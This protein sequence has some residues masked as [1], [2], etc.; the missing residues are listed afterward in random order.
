MRGSGLADHR[1]QRAAQAGFQGAVDAHG[2]GVHAQVAAAE[3]GVRHQA[4]LRRQV[5]QRGERGDVVRVQPHFHLA[6]AAAHASIA[7]PTSCA[8]SAGSAS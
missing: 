3:A 4:L 7:S 6:G 2:F 5:Q 8:S 1:V